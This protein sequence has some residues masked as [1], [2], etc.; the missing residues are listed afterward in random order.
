MGL[1]L[2][3]LSEWSAKPQTPD[4]HK[5]PCNFERDKQT[6]LASAEE[7]YLDISVAI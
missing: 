6:A 4:G 1:G 5:C 2:T 3:Q 7:E